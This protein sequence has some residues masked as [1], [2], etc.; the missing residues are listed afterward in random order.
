MNNKEKNE[1]YA[2][3]MSKLK[4]SINN[5]FYYE[6][7]FIEYA[8]LEDRAESLLRHAKIPQ[9]DYNGDNLNLNGKLKKIEHSIKFNKDSYVSNHISFK[10]LSEIHDWKNRRN[11]LIHDL[12]KSKYNLDE[13]VKKIAYEGYD[14]IKILNGKSALVNKYFDKKYKE[15]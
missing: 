14:I 4:R 11:V 13:D 8:I 5:E 6:S 7:I 10:L 9:F 1:K 12:I 2:V 3:L 15:N